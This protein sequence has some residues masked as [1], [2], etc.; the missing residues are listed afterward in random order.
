VE[1]S[2]LCLK[3]HNRTELD[4]LE[5]ADKGSIEYRYVMDDTSADEI[6][7]QIVQFTRDNGK[8]LV[9]LEEYFCVHK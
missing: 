5:H 3:A 1:D 6:Y 2:C 9:T 8:T 4:W 7:T